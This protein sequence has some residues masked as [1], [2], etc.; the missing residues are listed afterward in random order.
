MKPIVAAALATQ[1]Q[2]IEANIKYENMK[3]KTEERP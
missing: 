3:K 1:Q 2:I